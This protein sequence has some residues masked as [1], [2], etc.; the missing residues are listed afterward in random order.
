MEKSSFIYSAN[1]GL[2]L[3]FHGCDKSVAEKVI[4]GSEFLRPSTNRYDWLGAGIYFWQNNYERAY[5]FACQQARM[6]KVK[7]P[8]VIG[9]VINLERCLDLIDKS[10]ID[11]LRSAWQSTIATLGH[12]SLPGNINPVSD[13]QSEDKV[14]RF[15]DSVVLES[16]HSRMVET[17]KQPYDTVRCAFIEG[18]P[19]YPGASFMDKSHIQICVRNPNC[20]KGLFMPRVMQPWNGDVFHQTVAAPAIAS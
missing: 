15:L 12:Q 18:Q 11:V 3:C 13:P 5:D 19:I 8:A 20:I 17:K 14:L 6:G 10:S 2:L 4:T 16:V 1:E 9:A 7:E